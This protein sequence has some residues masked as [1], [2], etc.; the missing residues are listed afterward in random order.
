[1]CYAGPTLGSAALQRA[2]LPCEA[3]RQKSFAGV[4]AHAAEGAKHLKGDHILTFFNWLGRQT[5]RADD[6]GAFARY[7]VKDRLF[8]RGARKLVLFLLRYEGMPE[9]REAVKVAHREWRRSRK[10]A[11]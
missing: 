8:P 10:V 2:P 11:A 5:A 9:Q 7:A 6:V 4:L 1:M 3:R